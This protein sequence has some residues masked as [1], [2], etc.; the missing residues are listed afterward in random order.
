MQ[1][2]KNATIRA[3]YLMVNLKQK[4]FMQENLSVAIEPTRGL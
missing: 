1:S 3:R 2:A 4:R